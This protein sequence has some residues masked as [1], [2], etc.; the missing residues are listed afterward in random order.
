M[1]LLRMDANNTTF[2]LFLKLIG[3]GLGPHAPGGVA[4]WTPFLG[5]SLIHHRSSTLFQGVYFRC[6]KRKTGRLL[7]SSREEF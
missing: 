2:Y 4:S 3:T 1:A 7:F 5:L 6:F